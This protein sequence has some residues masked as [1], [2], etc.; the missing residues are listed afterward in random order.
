MCVLC[1]LL[2]CIPDALLN[3]TQ[4]DEKSGEEKKKRQWF[5]L[6]SFAARRCRKR[7]T[8]G[9]IFIQK[10]AH[11]HTHT[12]TCI[13]TGKRRI[14]HKY[15]LCALYGIHCIPTPIAFEI[16]QFNAL[17]KEGGRNEMNK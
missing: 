12:L 2:H 10:H 9:E 6:L 11:A 14:A 13:R 17:R 5:R 15:I 1:V 8:K 16:L 4:R 7:N 3:K